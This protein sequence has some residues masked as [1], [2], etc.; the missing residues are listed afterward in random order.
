MKSSLLSIPS[1]IRPALSGL[2]LAACA[3]TVSAATLEERLAR[4]EAATSPLSAGDNAWLLAST[5]LVLMM[6][7]K[8]L[9][10][11]RVSD[12]D[13]DTGLD[14]TEHGESAYND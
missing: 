13:E 1:R 11:L 5:A 12:E 9:V 4:L 8:A 14:L 2:L 10:G 6:I 3:G 7:V